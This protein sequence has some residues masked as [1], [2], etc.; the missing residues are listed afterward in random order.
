LLEQAWMSNSPPLARP[1][2][3]LIC[4]RGAIL[5]REGLSLWLASF[6]DLVGI[7][8]LDEPRSRTRRRIRKQI[9][10]S[11]LLRF[12]DVLALR[13]W[14]RVRHARSDRQF[15]R[16][17]VDRIRARFPATAPSPNLLRS[18]SVNAP[19]VI[20]FLQRS[21][22]DFV[23]A[24]C[25]TLL[26]PAVFEVPAAGTYV[27]HPGVCPEYRNAHGCFWALAQRDLE[28]VG[29]TLLRIDAGVDTGPIYGYFSYAF[30]ERRESHIRI[31]Q[32]VLL[33]NLDAVRD[34]L[35]SAVA[36]AAERIQTSGRR[37]ATWGQPWLTAYLRWKRAAR[38]R[39]HI[40]ES[41]PVS[42][43]GATA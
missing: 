21:R 34:T 36:G 17:A 31:Q 14:Y 8:E 5:D 18:S 9:Q 2:S 4:H 11:G 19:E 16:D 30:D 25:K 43:R 1:R 42:R 20:E 33:E 26:K 28:R 40:H 10:R 15:E 23:V 35:L 7:V 39:G 12:L 38:R 27:L 29:L 24:R 37:S 3:V 22:P 6:S 32:R 41:A 13:A